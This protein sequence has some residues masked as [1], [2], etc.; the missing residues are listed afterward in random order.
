MTFF[1]RAS[2]FEIN[3]GQFNGVHNVVGNIYL[4]QHEDSSQA[5]AVRKLV[6]KD[7]SLNQY[8]AQHGT[9]TIPHF[10]KSLLLQ[11]LPVD[12]DAGRISAGSCSFDLLAR[13][14]LFP[15]Q[16]NEALAE[17]DADVPL[18]AVV[19]RGSC[20]C[21]RISRHG[22]VFLVSKYFQHAAMAEVAGGGT[23]IVLSTSI[24]R[25]KCYEIEDR[26]FIHFDSGTR[27]SHNDLIKDQNL[28]E[29][30]RIARG[31]YLI[32]NSPQRMTFEWR[33]ITDEVPEDIAVGDFFGVPK[34]I[35]YMTTSTLQRWKRIKQFANVMI[36]AV[37][38]VV[39]GLGEPVPFVAALNNLPPIDH[40]VPHAVVTHPS[41]PAEKLASCVYLCRVFSRKNIGELP[42]ESFHTFATLSTCDLKEAHQHF[43][44]RPVDHGRFITTSRDRFIR[45]LG[46]FQEVNRV[47]GRLSDAPVRR[48]LQTLLQ[49]NVNNVALVV[50]Q[51]FFALFAQW[52]ASRVLSRAREAPDE[53]IRF[54]GA[55]DDEM[56]IG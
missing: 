50:L 17:Y 9:L 16:P 39:D 24:G 11:D 52:N 37:L 20:Y 18:D 54:V 8:S 36:D 12:P 13:L 41:T 3:G 22:F 40:R 15:G 26:I 56:Y 27:S 28:E 7:A 25:F 32:N 46:E 21:G 2:E 19:S 38:S 5:S 33:R 10:S 51:G 49:S 53:W 42:F 47:P 45:I 55:D 23:C 43:R 29:I 34:A 14:G 6:E 4:G 31:E 44:G 30:L 35:S 1:E 48:E